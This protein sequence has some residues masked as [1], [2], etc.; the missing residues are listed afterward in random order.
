M[1]SLLTR[2]LVCSR[3]R[4][5]RRASYRLLPSSFDA[6]INS[7]ELIDLLNSSRR[8]IRE[9]ISCVPS[10]LRRPEEMAAELETVPLKKLMAW[11]RR[12]K[13]PVPHFRPNKQVTRFSSRMV[14][15]WLDE[16]CRRRRG[17]A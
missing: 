12:F 11:T 15:E 10:D 17:V 6:F 8:G 14:R 13:N 5:G 7:D 3:L 2:E 16:N 1:G 9:P 4:I